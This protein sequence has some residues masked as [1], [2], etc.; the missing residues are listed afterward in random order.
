MLL[1]RAAILLEKHTVGMHLIN[2][3]HQRGVYPYRKA[4]ARLFSIMIHFELNYMELIQSEIILL[5]KMAK[6]NPREKML[7]NAFYSFLN[8]IQKYPKRKETLLLKF[9]NELEAISIKNPGYFDFISFDYFKWS[10]RLK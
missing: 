7:I 4:Q 6:E 1:V 9:Q 5:K 8:S 2:Q 3:W 10:K